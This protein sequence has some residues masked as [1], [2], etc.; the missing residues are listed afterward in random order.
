ME[1][2]AGEPPQVEKPKFGYAD[3]GTGDDDIRATAMPAYR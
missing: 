3:L 1:G 2:K